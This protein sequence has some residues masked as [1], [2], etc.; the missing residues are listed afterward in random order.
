MLKLEIL[1]FFK[2]RQLYTHTHEQ[3]KTQEFSAL[4]DKKDIFQGIV[5][6]FRL[7]YKK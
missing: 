3:M 4:T 7:S 6:E 1:I 2:C 5:P